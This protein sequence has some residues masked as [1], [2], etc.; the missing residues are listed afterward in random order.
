MV[1]GVAQRRNVGECRS[2]KCRVKQGSASVN[3]RQTEHQAESAGMRH[4]VR[5]N[6]NAGAEDIL[7]GPLIG[8]LL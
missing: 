8:R 5:H 7:T 2:E 4:W 6:L 3:V 1:V